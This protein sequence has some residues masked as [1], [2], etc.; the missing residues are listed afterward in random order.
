MKLF[1]HSHTPRCETKP[2]WCHPMETFSA[3][4][5]ICAGNSPVTGEFPTQ[6]PVFEMRL[7]KQLSKQSWGW[8]YGTPSCPLWRHCDVFGYFQIPTAWPLLERKT[9]EIGLLTENASHKN[10]KSMRFCIVSYW[11]MTLQKINIA[12]IARKYTCNQSSRRS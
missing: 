6:K 11:F 10:F 8:W 7:N 9:S 12:N 2:W 1:N 5:A 3:L 4:L